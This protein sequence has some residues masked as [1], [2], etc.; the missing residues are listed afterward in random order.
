MSSAVYNPDSEIFRD[1]IYSLNGAGFSMVETEI[2]TGL[3][4]HGQNNQRHLDRKSAIQFSVKGAKSGV[5]GKIPK[6]PAL[7]CMPSVPHLKR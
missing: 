6:V 5:A 2:L 7:E 4:N 1:E 3:Q